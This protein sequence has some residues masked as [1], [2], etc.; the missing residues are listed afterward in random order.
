MLVH[1]PD[2]MIHHTFKHKCWVCKAQILSCQASLVSASAQQQNST[3]QQ[4]Y[5]QQPELLQSYQAAAKRIAEL[6]DEQQNLKHAACPHDLKLSEKD[7]EL[8]T[9]R[10]SVRSVAVDHMRQAPASKFS[11]ALCTNASS[12]KCLAWH[13][14]QC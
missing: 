7:S 8:V 11:S 13:Q 14:I 4:V 5:Q 1:I 9:A 10:H 3:S 12:M 6:E 2:V